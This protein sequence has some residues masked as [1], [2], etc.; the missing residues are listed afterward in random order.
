MEDGLRDKQMQRQVA[1]VEEAA[2]DRLQV[3][4]RAFAQK[5]RVTLSRLNE[6]C[7]KLDPL[8]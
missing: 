6:A 8:R 7:H 2:D 3:V 5:Q 4:K 1:A